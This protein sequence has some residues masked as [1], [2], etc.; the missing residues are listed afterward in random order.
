[1]GVGIFEGASMTNPNQPPVFLNE[2]QVIQQFYFSKSTCYRLIK[3]GGFPR[4][5]RISARRVGWLQSELTHHIQQLTAK[6]G[7]V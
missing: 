6:N 3:T 1:V 4:A 2:K 7:G 5:H